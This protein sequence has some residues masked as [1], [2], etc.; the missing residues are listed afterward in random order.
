MQKFARLDRESAVLYVCSAGKIAYYF[1]QRFAK[2]KGK[3]AEVPFPSYTPES[4]FCKAK[5]RGIRICMR[6]VVV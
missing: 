6:V 3:S 1:R 5:W 2:K 4:Q